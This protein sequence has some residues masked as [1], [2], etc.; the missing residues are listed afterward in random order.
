MNLMFFPNKQTNKKYQ[1]QKNPTTVTTNQTIKFTTTTTTDQTIKPTVGT[2]REG[3]CLSQV[4]QSGEK[5]LESPPSLG[6]GTIYIAPLRGRT[7]LTT[8]VWV[9]SLGIGMGRC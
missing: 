9:W 5:M 3:V 1:T 4:D 7:D 6:L 8:K 2:T